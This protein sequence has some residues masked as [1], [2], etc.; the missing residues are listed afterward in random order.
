MIER[1]SDV[2]HELLDRGIDFVE[3][4]I[5][6]QLM[7]SE[8][9]FGRSDSELEEFMKLIENKFYADPQCRDLNY[10]IETVLSG[11][12]DYLWD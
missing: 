3:L 6:N 4:Y 1:I 10:H 9:M 11:G 2:Y 5:Y 12:D 7:S 8:E